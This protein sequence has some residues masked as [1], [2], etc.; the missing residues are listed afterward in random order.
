VRRI[1]SLNAEIATMD[2]HLDRSHDLEHIRAAQRDEPWLRGAPVLDQ[3]IG[4]ER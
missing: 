4:L 1:D 2:A 3:S